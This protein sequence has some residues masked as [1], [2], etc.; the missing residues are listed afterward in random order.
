M[1]ST[2]QAHGKLLLTAEYFVLDGAKALAVPV[3]YGQSLTVGKEEEVEILQ[4]KSV[5]EKGNL[6]FEASFHPETFEPQNFTDKKLADRLTQIFC[7]AKKLNGDQLR[8]QN[9]KLE[10]RL[11]FPNNWGLGTSSTLIY[12][13][14]KWT[15]VNPFELQF[16]TF[17]G[18][19]YDIACA[20]AEGP[21]FYRLEDG[22]PEVETCD[23]APSFAGQLY[24]I[25]LGKKQNSREGIAKYRNASRDSL[26]RTRF[27]MRSETVSAL[28]DEFFSAKTLD[29]FEKVIVEHEYLVGQSV[30]M[31]RAK[32]LYFSDFWGEIKSLG[33]W[34]GDFV[35]A[36]SD[37]P[38]EVTKKY[39]NEKGFEVFFRYEEMVL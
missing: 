25:F 38:F 6:W 32:S 37:R 24:F 16:K 27:G 21:I 5:D 20:G 2:F 35:M 11:E 36:T 13:L 9:F 3:K 31:S 26:S 28:T 14:A 22:K 8:A 1:I 18:S 23:F 34:G 15:G 33:A 39:F 10:T 19:G 17:G 30:G 29:G 12:L 7:E 4:W